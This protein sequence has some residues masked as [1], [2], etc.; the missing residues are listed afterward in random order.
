MRD[1]VPRITL[2]RVELPDHR[3]GHSDRATQGFDLV[4]IV[5]DV[6]IEPRGAIL[7]GGRFDHVFGPQPKRHSKQDEQL[8]EARLQILLEREAVILAGAAPHV[9]V[10]TP[11][12]PLL[13]DL[14]KRDVWSDL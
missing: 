10:Q 5:E 2:T 6:R 11:C 13:L 3:V 7:H 12:C 1:E 14:C 4:I 8:L 9:V